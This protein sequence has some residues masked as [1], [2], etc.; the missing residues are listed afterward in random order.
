MFGHLSLQFPGIF[1]FCTLEI[2]RFAREVSASTL[3]TIKSECKTKVGREMRLPK[4]NTL[5]YMCG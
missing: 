3:S 5:T 2:V 1:F 4:T